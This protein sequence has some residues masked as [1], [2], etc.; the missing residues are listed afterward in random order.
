M[1]EFGCKLVKWNALFGF[2]DSHADIDADECRQN[3][4]H[5]FYRHRVP[6]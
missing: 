6:I 2:V 5:D 4:D 3:E 1:S